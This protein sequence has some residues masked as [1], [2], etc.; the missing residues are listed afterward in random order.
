M[1]T[2]CPVAAEVSPQF[3]P[4]HLGQPRYHRDAGLLLFG[5]NNELKIHLTKIA[6]YLLSYPT[7]GFPV[8]NFGGYKLWL[9]P[10]HVAVMAEPVSVCHQ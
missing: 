7:Y 6:V 8:E 10:T 5:N 1:S 2:L 9:K 3:G 4:I